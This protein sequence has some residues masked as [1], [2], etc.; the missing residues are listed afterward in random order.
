MSA[1]PTRP[2]PIIPFPTAISAIPLS[3]HSALE[4]GGRGHEP[5]RL[6]GE[7]DV[8][9]AVGCA[10]EDHTPAL[11]CGSLVRLIGLV[12]CWIA[13]TDA[14]DLPDAV[15]AEAHQILRCRNHAALRIH[16]IDFDHRD[17]LA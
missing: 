14:P 7:A 10:D 1:F 16:D 17:I 12:A 5:R 6:G 11:E 3:T 4:R 13:V 9:G 2:I 8:A 15:Q